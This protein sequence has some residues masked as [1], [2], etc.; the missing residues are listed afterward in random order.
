MV[1]VIEKQKKMIKYF[2]LTAVISLIGYILAIPI[3]NYWGAAW[4]TVLSELMIVASAWIVIRSEVRLHIPWIAIAKI[5]VASLAMGAVTFIT[6]SLLPL[7]I[8]I[9]ISFL[10]Y[11]LLIYAFRIVPSDELK[12]LIT[13]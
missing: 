12:R 5:C 8:T 3:Y 2:F 6:A 11:T 9:S 7:L 13:G 1:L 10:C 4:M